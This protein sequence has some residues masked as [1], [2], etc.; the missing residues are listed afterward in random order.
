MDTRSL[1]LGEAN[2]N[3]CRPASFAA[4]FGGQCR[5]VLLGLCLVATVFGGTVS[6]TSLPNRQSQSRFDIH[7]IGTWP[8]P[9]SPLWTPA[10]PAAKL[11]A[12]VTPSPGLTL[13]HYYAA[14]GGILGGIILLILIVML[15]AGKRL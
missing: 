6:S 13:Q 2:T 5:Q 3:R 8:R 9:E 1:R 7:G 10:R 15:V 12:P 11:A 4:L 14:V